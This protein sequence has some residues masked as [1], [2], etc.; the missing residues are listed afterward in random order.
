MLLKKFGRHAGF[1]VDKIQQKKCQ[2]NYLGFL[3]SIKLLN[4]KQ[5]KVRAKNKVA[6]QSRKINYRKAS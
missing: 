1:K 2:E 5:K 6:K 3:K 4:K